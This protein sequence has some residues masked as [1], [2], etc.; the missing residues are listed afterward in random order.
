MRHQELHHGKTPPQALEAG[1]TP[2]ETAEE[3]EGE[4]TAPSA[5]DAPSGK[6]EKCFPDLDDQIAVKVEMDELPVDAGCSSGGDDGGDDDGADAGADVGDGEGEDGG[7]DTAP[8]PAAAASDDDDDDEGDFDDPPYRPESDS[9]SDISE[10]NDQRNE[11]PASSARPVVCSGE[12][13]DVREEDQDYGEEETDPLRDTADHQPQRDPIAIDTPKTEKPEENNQTAVVIKTEP[14]DMDEEPAGAEDSHLT[15]PWNS[16]SDPELDDASARL[17]E[18]E[19]NLTEMFIDIERMRSTIRRKIAANAHKFDDAV[20]QEAQSFVRDPEPSIDHMRS[21]LRAKLEEGKRIQALLANSE[22]EKRPPHSDPEATAKKIK[23]EPVESYSGTAMTTKRPAIAAT[24]PL[25]K[26]AAPSP[27]GQRVR[28]RRLAPATGRPWL[29]GR[30]P[31]GRGRMSDP[32]ATPRVPRRRWIQHELN[33]ASEE[34]SLTDVP[35]IDG[36]RISTGFG[37]L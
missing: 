25:D 35:P 26:P 14:K 32:S 11:A 29:V 6:T 12:T 33:F 18:P 27:D 3:T 10:G 13:S 20:T 23:V 22:A 30:R 9:E 28:V 21:I 8:A 5:E 17:L 19:V 31:T 2:T 37:E 34:G 7:G 15:A 16:D 1:E 4:V 24:S 36:V